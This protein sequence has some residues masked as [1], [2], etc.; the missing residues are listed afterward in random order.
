MSMPPLQSLLEP[1]A[2]GARRI[3]PYLLTEI[4]L[5]GGTVLALLLFLA[6]HRRNRLARGAARSAHRTRCRRHAS[7]SVDQ[8]A[9]A[10]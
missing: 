10:A 7:S 5:P 3:A 1:L 4:L 6:R 9:R 8:T 2:E